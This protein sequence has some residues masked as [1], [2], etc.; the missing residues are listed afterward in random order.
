MFKAWIVA[1]RLDMDMATITANLTEVTTDLENLQPSAEPLH[2]YVY[3]A[4][5]KSVCF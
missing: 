2:T 1:F 4:I 3:I 5:G